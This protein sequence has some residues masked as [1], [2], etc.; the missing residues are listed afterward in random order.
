MVKLGLMVLMT[1]LGVAGGLVYA[2]FLPAAIYHFYA[3][4]RPQYIWGNDLEPIVGQDFPWSLALAL[5]AIVSAIVWRVSFWI[6]PHR[7]PG[8]IL[9]KLNVGHFLFGFFA[10]WI[11][12]SYINGEQPAAAERFIEDYRKIFLMFYITCL[13]MVTIRQVGLLYIL[14]TIGFV[15]I[16]FEDN[17][18]YYF[19]GRYNYRDRT[20]AGLDNNGAALLLAMGVP[21]CIYAWDGIR[22]WIRWAFPIGILLIVHAVLI[23]MSRGAMLALMLTSPLY[24]LRCRNKKMIVAGYLAAAIVV[25]ILASDQ[26]TARFSTIKESEKD[27]SAQNRFTTWNIAWNMANERPFFGYGVRTSSQYTHKYGADE[28]GRVIHSTYLQLAA[29]S[30]LVGLAAYLMF[31]S[32]AFYCGA[33]ACNRTNR[34]LKESPED[35]NAH[36]AYSASCGAEGSLAVFVVGA[37]FLSLET[38]EPPYIV[39]MM[40]IQLWSIVQVQSRKVGEPI[41]SA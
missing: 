34:T 20:F 19:H 35:R 12:A 30:G 33:R 36:I 32:G 11:T 39:A 27:A 15:F 37:A 18:L 17:Q 3:V 14:I 8:I 23:S 41:G 7:Y 38:F 1:G 31:L 25:P 21:L 16:A 24:L 5:S 9:P 2:P 22:H 28:E 4:L 6:A 40:A 13:V 29:D 10:L 26:I